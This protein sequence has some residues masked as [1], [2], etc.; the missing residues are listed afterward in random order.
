MIIS[1][2][3]KEN[4]RNIF[5]SWLSTTADQFCNIV[6]CDLSL[7][8]NLFLIECTQVTKN[9]YLTPYFS[10]DRIFDGVQFTLNKT[11]ITLLLLSLVPEMVY[12]SNRTALHWVFEIPTI[13]YFPLIL[14]QIGKIS[15]DWPIRAHKVPKYEVK[16]S[17]EIFFMILIAKSRYK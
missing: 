8:I 5:E 15:D 13:F 2:Q 1:A 16:A 9:I 4:C 12:C 7:F 3:K 11:L 10:N 14:F 17:N 6:F